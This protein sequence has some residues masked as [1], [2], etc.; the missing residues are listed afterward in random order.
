MFYCIFH[1]ACTDSDRNNTDGFPFHFLSAPQFQ[2]G[3]IMLLLLLWCPW[4]STF[5]SLT[6]ERFVAWPHTLVEAFRMSSSST[7]PMKYLRMYDFKLYIPNRKMCIVQ[8]HTVSDKSAGI[9]WNS[10]HACKQTLC[11]PRFCTSIVAQDKNGHVYHG[12]NLDYPHPVLR[13]LTV[14]IIFLKNGE[15]QYVFKASENETA[16]VPLTIPT[17]IAQNQ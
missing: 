17:K 10:S 7:L 5:L 9:R 2:N 15:V 4:K 1:H 8:R 6:Q 11:I 14:N 13:N 12:R 3:C 16:V